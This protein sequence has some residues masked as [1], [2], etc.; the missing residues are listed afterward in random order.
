MTKA[1]QAGIIKSAGAATDAAIEGIIRSTNVSDFP[2]VFGPP[3]MT[4]YDNGVPQPKVIFTYVPNY[5]SITGL[6]QGLNDPIQLA[7]FQGVAGNL[8]NANLAFIAPLTTNADFAGTVTVPL[9]LSGTLAFTDIWSD[10]QPGRDWNTPPAI[11]TKLS[12]ENT[13]ALLPSDGSCNI[14]DRPNHHLQSQLIQPVQLRLCN[15]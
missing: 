5:G 6:G 4:A 15:S 7:L 1:N 13:V 3:L 11:P 10:L 12:I 14:N 9:R 8:T 2:G